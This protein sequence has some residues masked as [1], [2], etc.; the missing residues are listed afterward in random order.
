V[1]KK[2]NTNKEWNRNHQ[3]LNASPPEPSLAELAIKYHVDDLPSALIPGT[4]ISKII[5]H[6]ELDE[7]PISNNALEFLRSRGF[8]ALLHYAKK[9]FSFAEFSKLAQ[10]EQSERRLATKAEALK[11]RAK[12]N[13]KQDEQRLKE[14]A[15]QARL[16]QKQERR[17]AEKLAFENDPRNIAKAKQFKL[18]QKYG[19]SYFIEKTDFPKLMEILHRVDSGMRLSEDDVVWLT[20]G[21]NDYFTVQLKECYHKIEADYYADEFKKSKDPWTA[22]NASSHYR[23]CRE[24]GIAESILNTI[25]MSGLKNRK[26][27]SALCTTHGGVKRDLAKWNE[28]LCLGEQAHLLTPKDFRPCT[29]LGAVNI[30]IGHYDLG[31]SWYEKAVQRGYSEK[32]VDDDLRTIFMR[33]EKNKKEALRDY[34]LKIDPRRYSWAKKKPVKNRHYNH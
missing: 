15:M 18:R 9:E 13:L 30:E 34:L 11:E 3:D 33:A 27:K 20:T 28:A 1:Y 17:T 26:L 14:V 12:Q 31:K 29:L 19:L 24:P 10:P 5:K 22:V 8:L 6:L 4:S 21:D 23:K 32:S 2:N 25:D 7:K 16:W